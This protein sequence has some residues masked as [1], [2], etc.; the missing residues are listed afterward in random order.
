MADPKRD[1]AIF[2]CYVYLVVDS[3]IQLTGIASVYSA[4]HL[5][6]E[7]MH[8]IMT[9]LL[10]LMMITTIILV[11]PTKP[12]LSIPLLG[13]DWLGSILWSMFML[14]FT[15][16]CVYGN[17]Y[18]WWEA[19]EIRTATW[20][21]IAFL[22]I[23][24][25]RASFLHHPYISFRAM[26][27]YNFLRATA[28]YI[29]FFTLLATEHVFEHTYAARVLGFDET[30]LIDLNW[31]VLWGILAGCVFTYLTFAL[32][33]WSYKSMTAISFALAVIYLGWFYFMIDYGVE[34][35]SLFLPLFC[36]GFASVVI[37]II[38]LT[39][40]VQS[41]LPFEIFP[42]ALT[43]NGFTG[44]VMSATFGPAVIG[45]LLSHI[46]ATDFS[47][48]SSD[49][50]STNVTAK[51]I[52]VEL[53]A[54]ETGLQALLLAMKEIFGW[55]VIAAILFLLI[56]LISYG[57]VKPMAIFPKWRT[58]RRIAKRMARL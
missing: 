28:I 33:R 16:I 42:Q 14:G 12:A 23:N 50:T 53:L 25:W 9:G 30:N 21:T 45:E 19:P 35:E 5:N 13:M 51:I 36:R 20:L 52:P 27:N 38:Y 37:S 58:I 32:R 31:Y 40:I 1:M 34:K 8:M 7:L 44:V 48:L 17:Y 26:T 24:L 29:I 10:A 54:G 4:F 2:F 11:K 3:A 15:F 43:L 57:P 49:L 22:A 56:I 39:S 55:L 41:G 47:V 46:T 6:W 18:D